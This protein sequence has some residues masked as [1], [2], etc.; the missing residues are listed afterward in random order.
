MLYYKL[1][2]KI[3]CILYNIIFYEEKRELTKLYKKT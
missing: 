2:L 3:C 1:K